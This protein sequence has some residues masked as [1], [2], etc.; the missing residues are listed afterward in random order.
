M[1]NRNLIGHLLDLDFLEWKELGGAGRE[2]ELA[3]GLVALAIVGRALNERGELLGRHG[4]ENLASTAVAGVG[5]DLYGRL[6]VRHPGCN[7][8]NCDEVTQVLSANIADR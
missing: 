3:L 8:A 5:I 2:E 4:L 7:T 6:D 1:A